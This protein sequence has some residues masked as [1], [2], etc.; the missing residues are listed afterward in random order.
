MP[1]TTATQNQDHT[2]FGPF[3]TNVVGMVGGSTPITVFAAG[4]VATGI[5]SAPHAHTVGAVGTGGASA[6]HAH[7]GTTDGYNADHNHTVTGSTA[8]G[9][10]ANPMSV[11][12]PWIAIGKVIKVASPQNQ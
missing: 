7:T 11:M 10:T 5:Q 8:A 1:F 3:A 6:N 4:T 9:G 2:H 12:P